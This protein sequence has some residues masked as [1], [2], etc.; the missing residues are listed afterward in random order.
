MQSRLK[1][2]QPHVLQIV[3]LCES[4]KQAPLS[5]FSILA[6]WSAPVT[7]CSVFSSASIKNRSLEILQQ[8]AK[9]ASDSAVAAVL[10][11]V[12]FTDDELMQHC[13]SWHLVKTF[14][15]VFDTPSANN[16]FKKH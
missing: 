10:Q 14:L 6:S 4:Q 8:Q 9:L 16:F 1:K 5:C 3:S 12:D 11:R 15:G 2:L 13:V 7:R